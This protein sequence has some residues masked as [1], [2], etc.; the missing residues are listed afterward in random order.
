MEVFVIL[1]CSWK[2]YSMV[3][4]RFYQHSLLSKESFENKSAFIFP[5]MATLPFTSLSEQ[6]KTIEKGWRLIR[7]GFVDE[8]HCQRHTRPRGWVECSH[9]SNCW[10]QVFTPIFFIKIKHQDLDQTS[11]SIYWQKICFKIQIKLQPQNLVQLSFNQSTS[12]VER[13]LVS[14]PTR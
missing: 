7:N 2:T 6:P 1:K 5:I 12:G 8:K 3:V 10:S 14:C 13:L 9:Q 11:T 4:I